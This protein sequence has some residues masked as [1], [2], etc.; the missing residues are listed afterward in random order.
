MVG[1]YLKEYVDSQVVM[2]IFYKVELRRKLIQIRVSHESTALQT[3]Y[4]AEHIR[5]RRQ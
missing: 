3:S 2:L 5:K 1:D 4:D